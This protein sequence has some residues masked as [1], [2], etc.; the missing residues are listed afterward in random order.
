MVIRH[1]KFSRVL[2]WRSLESLTKVNVLIFQTGI[3]CGKAK[4]LSMESTTEQLCPTLASHGL[5]TTAKSGSGKPVLA[6]VTSTL[7][8]YWNPMIQIIQ[9]SKQINWDVDIFGVRLFNSFFLDSF[10]VF[11]TVVLQLNISSLFASYASSPIPILTSVDSSFLLLLQLR[12]DFPWFS[13]LFIP[14]W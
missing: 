7:S 12:S 14:F 9:N 8:C 11:F 3:F 6:S 4:M 13:S 5:Y 10:L 1:M 2:I